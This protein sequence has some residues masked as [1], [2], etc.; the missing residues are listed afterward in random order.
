MAGAAMASDAGC[1]GPTN[2]PGKR[3]VKAPL[4]KVGT[5]LTSVSRIGAGV[6]RMTFYR[7]F[8]GKAD[9]AAE[10]FR[11]AAEE[12]L[13]RYLRIAEVDHADRAVV[14]YWLKSLFEADRANRRALRVFIQATA[15]ENHFTERAQKLIAR[16]IERLGET[17][18]AFAADQADPSER[19][20]WL[21]AWLL[22]YEILDQSNH[23]ALD[24][25]VAAD[26]LVLEI[27]ADRFL[28][29]VTKRAI[30]A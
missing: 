24:S 20:R 26:P 8:A 7:H 3:P 27:L 13:P 15:D 1:S 23:A 30:P 19:R 28:R 11:D 14:M 10:L 16:L 2:A 9:V 4:S 21:E 5:P 22:I 25:G 17:I 29:F 6:S 12:A 18:P